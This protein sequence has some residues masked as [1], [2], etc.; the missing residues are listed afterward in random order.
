MPSFRAK[1]MSESAD[2]QIINGIYL[3][4]YEQHLARHVRGNPTKLGAGTYQWPKVKAS[5]KLHPGRRRTAIDVGAHV[6]LWSRIYAHHFEKVVA[7]EPVTLHCDL[8]NR[9]L[10]DAENAQLHRV[11]LGADEGLAMFLWDP[12]NTGG[13]HSMPKGGDPGEATRISA[14]IMPLDSYHLGDVDLI[15]L[16]CEGYEFMAIQGGEKTIREHEPAIIIEQKP[17][18]AE[19]YGLGKTDAVQ[20]LESWG[21]TLRQEI[22]GDYLLSWD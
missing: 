13:T 15:K 20:L 21:A 2:Y 7:F 11:A 1:M 16:D 6:G 18:A 19:K 22:A 17:G 5:L 12:T 9:N 4:K 8:W 14:R 10:Q 3:P